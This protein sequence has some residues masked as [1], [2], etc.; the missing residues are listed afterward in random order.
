MRDESEQMVFAIERAGILAATA[1]ADL[2][3]QRKVDCSLT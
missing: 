1:G 3:R 2:N